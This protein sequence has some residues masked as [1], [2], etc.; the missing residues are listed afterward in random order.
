MIGFFP[1]FVSQVLL[2]LG[3][4]LPFLLQGKHVCCAYMNINCVDIFTKLDSNILVHFGKKK[5]KLRLIS[6]RINCLSL[7]HF[8][9]AI[10]H[11]H[12]GK[13]THTTSLCCGGK[14]LVSALAD[15]ML[16]QQAKFMSTLLPTCSFIF[17]SKRRGS[18]VFLL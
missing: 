17:I 11:Y 1:I 15:M 8:P 4:L 16:D 10:N 3:S 6:V 14:L 5:F 9:Q 7:T 2:S 13:R 12:Q 18:L